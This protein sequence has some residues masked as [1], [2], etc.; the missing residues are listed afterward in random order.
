MSLAAGQVVLGQYVLEEV[1]A[2]G[3][4]GSVWSAVGADGRQVAVK[5]IDA[6]APDV[7]SATRLARE[8]ALLSRV[9]HPNVVAMLAHGVVG[10]TPVIV[11]ELVGGRPLDALLRQRGALSAGLAVDWICQILAG[12]AALHAADIVHRDVKPANVLVTVEDDFVLKLIDLGAGRSLRAGTEK[13]TRAGRTIGT[14]EYMAPEQMADSSVDARADIYAAGMV[15]YQMLSGHLPMPGVRGAMARMKTPVA[16]PVLPPDL[17]PLSPSLS[18]VLL[19]MLA[20]DPAHRPQTALAASAAL[21]R[22]T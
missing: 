20:I 4:M 19:S 5:L 3:G 1:I 11:L 14:I 7:N 13:L 21:A 22:T 6:A 9:H 2:V 18:T 8:A 17:P 16:P 12:L 15:L 10:L